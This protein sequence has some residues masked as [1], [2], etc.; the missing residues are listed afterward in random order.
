MPTNLPGDRL[1]SDTCA[2]R[3]SMY[4]TLLLAFQ[5]EASDMLENYDYFIGGV[6]LGS[7]LVTI[8]CI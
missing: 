4:D 7:R 8:M 2:P 3:L 1:K 5:Q 6:G